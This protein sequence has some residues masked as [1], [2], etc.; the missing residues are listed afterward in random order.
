MFPCSNE[1]YR[2]RGVVKPEFITDF[3]RRSACK[4]ARVKTLAKKA[5]EIETMCGGNVIIHYT[6]NNRNTYV[7]CSQDKWNDYTASVRT[8]KPTIPVEMSKMI[9]HL[10]EEGESSAT[11][12]NHGKKWKVNVVGGSSPTPA[13]Q[14]TSDADI[15]LSTEIEHPTPSKSSMGDVNFLHQMPQ[16]NQITWDEQ[17]EI[18]VDTPETATEISVD[19][20]ET[21]TEISVD[22]PETA[23]TTIIPAGG[24]S[25]EPTPGTSTST[26]K[27]AQPTQG[28]KR[29]PK[30]TLLDS[31]K[32]IKA[33]I[34]SKA[35]QTVT[36]HKCHFCEMDYLPEEDNEDNSGGSWIGCETCDTWAH[37][38]CAGFTVNDVKTRDWKCNK[39]IWIPVSC[40]NICLSRILTAIEISVCFLSLA[41]NKLNLWSANHIP[42]LN[43]GCDW[44]IPTWASSEQE[45]E[46]I[47]WSLGSVC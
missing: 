35:K 38:K 10:D 13:P 26:N 33:Y 39:C 19:T 7:Y 29:K 25:E 32:R 5:H 30:R 8:G 37:R 22:T 34:K 46:N 40:L 21:A 47:L 18:P 1:K 44:I 24:A 2:C 43:L 45:T 41:R 20:P 27:T 6:D 31:R 36:G 23:S 9:S 28:G 16:V 15:T 3:K 42:K 11:L 17:L 14:E 4:I 12:T